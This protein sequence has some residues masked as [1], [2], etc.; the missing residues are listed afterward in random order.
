MVH[1]RDELQLQRRHH[2][3]PGDLLLFQIIVVDHYTNKQIDHEKTA[4]NHKA[5]KEYLLA[6]RIV[7]L[8]RKVQPTCIDC[9]KHHIF[10]AL[11][12]HHFKHRFH[13]PKYMIEITISIDPLPTVIVTVPLTLDVPM[14]V[15][16]YI[17]MVA[18]VE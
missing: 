9:S 6:W 14:K 11:G 17:F 8:R 1:N 10:P 3:F 13:P 2:I 15:F 4:E 12:C 18:G 5:D 7:L 16:R